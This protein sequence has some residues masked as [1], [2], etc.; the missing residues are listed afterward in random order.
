MLKPKVVLPVVILSLGAFAA[1]ASTRDHIAVTGLSVSPSTFAVAGGGGAQGGATIRFRLSRPATARIAIA[2]RLRGRVAGHHCVRPTRKLAA[3]RRCT[4]FVA[5]GEIVRARERAGR[6][7]V[8]FSGRIGGRALAPGRYRAAVT[9]VDRAHRRSARRT[10]AFTV[11]RAGA[12]SPPSPP[13]PSPPAPSPLPP[14]SD[15]NQFPNESTTGTPAGWT[16]SVTRSTDMDVTTPGAVVHDIRFTNGAKLSIDAPNVTV[17]DVEIQGGM[18]DTA[19][20]NTLIEDSTLDRAAPETTGGE[21]AVSYC[22]YTAVR[23]KIVDRSE[24]FRE[25]GCNPGVVTTI[26]DSFVRITPP[27]WCENG[28]NTDWHGDGIQ[29]YNG[30]N[31]SVENVTIDFHEDSK[32]QATSPFFYNGGPGGSP[33][34]HA[35]VDRLLIRGGGISFRL[36]TPAPNSVRGLRIVDDSW[37]FSPIDVYASDGGGCGAIGPWEAKLVRV[38]SNWRVTGI[39][40]SLPCRNS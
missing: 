14:G 24:G 26:K 23:V 22:G 37:R 9:A 17:R 16:P 12:P 2:R 31:L 1:T 11:V 32:C 40:A 30:T 18:I 29:G 28:T 13:P 36:G 4:R 15:P 27:D 20:E 6:R 7:A 5:V 35:F 25:S 34:G 38:D 8:A 21:G 3:R 39:D 10:V 19:G 33:H